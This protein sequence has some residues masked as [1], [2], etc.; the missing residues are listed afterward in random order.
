MN[1][2]NDYIFEISGFHWSKCTVECAIRLT[3]IFKF[4]QAKCAV[5]NPLDWKLVMY[6]SVNCRKGVNSEGRSIKIFYPS[7]ETWKKIKFEL[8]K[9]SSWFELDFFPSMK[10][11]WFFKLE[12]GKNQVQIDRGFGFTILHLPSISTVFIP[13]QPAVCMF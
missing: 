5:V 11:T 2:F 12:N 9:I 4:A 7:P 8:E 13:L 6:I 10:Q 3:L 1:I